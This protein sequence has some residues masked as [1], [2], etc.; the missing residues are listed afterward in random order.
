MNKIYE[1]PTISPVSDVQHTMTC[2]VS[3]P[4]LAVYAGFV[5]V[6]FT[7]VGLHNNI[8]AVVHVAG[9]ALNYV[10]AGYDC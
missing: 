4:V 5:A 1:P 8:G 7:V 6:W 3:V 10:T 9:V 2:V